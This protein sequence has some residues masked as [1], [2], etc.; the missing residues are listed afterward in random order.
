MNISHTHPIYVDIKDNKGKSPLDVA[1]E[2]YQLDTAIYL[3]NHGCDSNEDKVKILCGACQFVK[4]KMMKE[5]IE[6]HNTNP[7]GDFS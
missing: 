7:K 1:L 3:M 6:T 4:L 2:N 5:L